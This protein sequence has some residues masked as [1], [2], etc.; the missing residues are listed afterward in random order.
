[1]SDFSLCLTVWIPAF[2]VTGSTSLSFSSIPTFMY[3]RRSP[4]AL[5]SCFQSGSYCFSLSKSPSTA[6][7]FLISSFCLATS[8]QWAIV[9]TRK[10]SEHLLRD[11]SKLFCSPFSLQHTIYVPLMKACG[12]EWQLGDTLSVA[13]F[14]GILMHHG[15]SHVVFINSLKYGWF[16]FITYYE[17]FCPLAVAL[18]EWKHL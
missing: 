8:L 17:V 5:L 3:L 13:G 2:Q 14:L 16:L 12:K 6:E 11:L 9:S 15:S 4:Y 7:R 10:R 1:M 18:L